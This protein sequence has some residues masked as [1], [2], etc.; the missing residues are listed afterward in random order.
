MGVIFRHSAIHACINGVNIK[1]SKIESTNLGQL[2]NRAY[3]GPG[4]SSFLSYFTPMSLCSHLTT[5]TCSYQQSEL[6]NS[7][8]VKEWAGP[9]LV[10]ARSLQSP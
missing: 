10:S 7:R 9:S 1:I 6:Y 3:P 2:Y 5:S 4:C 8:E